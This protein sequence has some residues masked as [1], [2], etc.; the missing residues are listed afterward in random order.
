M[1]KLRLSG[2]DALKKKYSTDVLL[3]V[4]FCRD[5]IRGI[6]FAEID[7]GYDEVEVEDR[8][9]DYLDE[10]YEEYLKIAEEEYG[11]TEEEFDSI[12]EIME[13]IPGLVEL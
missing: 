12:Y 7:C 1:K 6:K 2:L 13:D 11:L 4:K 3:Q 9:G 5:E 10:I 8:I